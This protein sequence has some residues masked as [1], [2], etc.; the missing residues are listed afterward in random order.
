LVSSNSVFDVS[1]ALLV[2]AGAWTAL[3]L[4]SFSRY[5]SLMVSEG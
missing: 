3:A 2:V 1:L 4:S 5:K